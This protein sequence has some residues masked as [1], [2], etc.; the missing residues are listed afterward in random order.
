MDNPNGT[1]KQNPRPF[2]SPVPHTLDEL[3]DVLNPAQF[4]RVN[5]QYLIARK[6]VRDIDL[7]FN[8]RLSVNLV[9]HVPEKILVSKV[10]AGDFKEW[11]MKG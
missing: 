8:S 5:R 9:V 1:K 7:W 10:R 4:F 6:A 3:A 2:V 11:F